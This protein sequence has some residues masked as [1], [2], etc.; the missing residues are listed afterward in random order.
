MDSVITKLANLTVYLAQIVLPYD[1]NAVQAAEPSPI[2]SF[3]PLKGLFVG[4]VVA[5]TLVVIFALR[6]KRR[7]RR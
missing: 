2:V 6:K 1:P 5:L 4:L 3:D 7:K